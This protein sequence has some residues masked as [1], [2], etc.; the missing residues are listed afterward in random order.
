MNL[1][2]AVVV[3]SIGAIS[4]LN[5]ECLAQEQ[6]T[7]G[8]CT[9]DDP[10][11]CGNYQIITNI[12]KPEEVHAD[13]GD[14]DN[15]DDDDVNDNDC[16]D[17]HPKCFDWSR[18][19]ECD[20]NPPYMLQSCSRSCKQCPDQAE[21][22]AVILAAKAKKVKVYT[23]E[24]LMIGED[25][26]EPQSLEDSGFRVSEKET[27]ARIVASREY[28]RDSDFDDELIEICLNKHEKCVAWAVSGECE[29][30]KKYM[31]A[32]CA[33]A[34]MTCDKL[35]IESRCPIDP[36]AKAAWESGSLEAMFKRLTSEPITTQYNVTILSSPPEPWVVIVD[37]VVTEEESK[38][39]IELGD[40]EGFKRSQDVGAKNPDG[41]Y[42]FIIK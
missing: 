35:T 28:L 18:I 36:D 1:L 5:F 4:L 16:Q 25:M 38:R 13:G 6:T 33:P 22:L 20:A 15:G 31:I 24:E 2:H 10:S 26:G 19:G 17:E 23:K 14:T 27:I 12:D 34:C 37:G 8:S 30:N 9:N 3:L 32:S 39:L 7:E 42:F 40:L 21:E 29:K 41:T 11:T